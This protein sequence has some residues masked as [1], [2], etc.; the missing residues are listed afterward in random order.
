MIY[1]IE[2]TEN[3]DYWLDSIKDIKLKARIAKRFDYVEMG[4]FGDHKS[5][6]SDLFE[7]RFFFGYRFRVY[8]TI[9]NNTIVFMLHG[10]D[11][12]SQKKDINKAKAILNELE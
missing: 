5:V 8:Y 3:F 4:N 10:G 6:G 2:T 1:E 7:L 9:K 11:K 12:D